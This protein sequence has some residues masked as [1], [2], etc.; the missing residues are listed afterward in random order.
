[1][2]V[3]QTQLILPS[4]LKKQATG[5][6]SQPEPPAPGDDKA[7]TDAI[8]EQAK[9]AGKARKVAQNPFPIEAYHPF[10]QEY[11]KS[12]HNC[13]GYP[14]DWYGA[15]MIPVVGVAIG[16]AYAAEYKRLP[17]WFAS[18]GGFLGFVGYSSSGKSQMMTHIFKPVD[19]MQRELLRKHKAWKEE[20]EEGLTDKQPGEPERLMLN[21][22]SLEKA[23]MLMVRNKKGLLVHRGELIGWM[24]SMNQYRKGDDQETW[25]EFFDNK[26]MFVDLV[27]Y[28]EPIWVDRPNFSVA[29]GIQDDLLHE[30]A[31]GNKADSGLF[32]R[33]LFAYADNPEKPLPNTLDPPF[34]IVNK[35]EQVVKRLF[36]YHSLITKDEDVQSILIPLTDGAKAAFFQYLCDSTKKSNAAENNLQRSI[37][38]KLETYTLRFCAML[39]LMDWAC[40]G[41]DIT[42]TDVVT[43]ERGYST[44]EGLVVD[45]EVLTRAL[46]LKDYFWATSQRVTTR[47]ENPVNKYPAI[48]QEWYRSLPFDEV[49][50]TKVAIDSAI[51]L[52]IA[53]RTAETLLS[54]VHLFKKIKTGWYERRWF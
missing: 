11:C 39:V 17:A 3:K 9:E 33:F 13:F 1:M 19:A 8:I 5:R 40:E 34:D 45:E 15:G 6:P 26:S 23:T 4:R 12:F 28:D 20:F 22:F 7:L 53:Q 41:R 52:S 47:I 32:G 51:G 36:S 18:P 50:K 37:L 21:K 2:S 16:N 27:K 14:L 29:G 42:A 38:G 48:Q 30:M 44:V 24:A 25:L 10:I 46:M 49:F 43:D 31:A 35:Y 54:N